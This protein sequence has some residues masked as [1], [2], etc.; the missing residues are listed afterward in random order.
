[1]KSWTPPTAV[2]L[3]QIKGARLQEEV[4]VLSDS[5]DSSDSDDQNMS[6]HAKSA[7]TRHKVDMEGGA[8]PWTSEHPMV[9]VPN[10][11]RH[12]DVIQVAYWDWLRKH[13]SKKSRNSLPVWWA[14]CSQMV[15]RMAW[16]D[17]LGSFQKGS[18]HYS[19]QLG[20]VLDAEECS[21]S[22]CDT[23]VFIHKSN[24]FIRLSTAGRH[25]EQDSRSGFR[26]H[27]QSQHQ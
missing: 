11:A 4:E 16:G 2:D 12:Y 19:F 3:L 26:C 7:S 27:L 15:D 22:S 18:L 14:D 24:E 8:A 5:P 25:P 9:G 21:P 17:E 1:M 23:F 10:T 13:P 6:W 20:R